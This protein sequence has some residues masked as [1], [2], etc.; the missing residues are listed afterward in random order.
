MKTVPVDLILSGV[1]V[2][3][4]SISRTAIE[5]FKSSNEALAVL[6]Q[7]KFGPPSRRS[8]KAHPIDGGS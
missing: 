6:Q 8:H 1:I 2:K 5:S 4:Q 7:E 3:I